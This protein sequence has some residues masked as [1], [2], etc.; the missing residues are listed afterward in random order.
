MIKKKVFFVILLLTLSAAMLFVLSGLTT[1]AEDGTQRWDFTSAN[2]SVLDD[3]LSGT[4]GK[5]YAKPQ[6]RITFSEQ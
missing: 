2:S 6:G 5:E 3:F 4:I 1:Y